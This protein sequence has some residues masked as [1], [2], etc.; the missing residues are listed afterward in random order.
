M[1]K[2]V[3]LDENCFMRKAKI[4]F[5]GGIKFLGGGIKTA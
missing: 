1:R 2:M 3:N 5:A 4:A